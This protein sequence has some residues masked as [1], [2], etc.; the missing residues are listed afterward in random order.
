MDDTELAD[1]DADSAK[2]GRSLLVG[3]IFNR[4]QRFYTLVTLGFLVFAS[5]TVSVIAFMQG[6]FI[7]QVINTSVF[8][9]TLLCLVLL[10]RSQEP[11][12]WPTYVAVSFMHIVVT[13]GFVTNGGVMFYAVATLPVIP[14]VTALL[15]GQRAAIV[16][17][18]YALLL[19]ICSGFLFAYEMHP[20]NITKA[21]YQPVLAVMLA[22]LSVSSAFVGFY[23]L[24]SASES[25]EMEV[26]KYTIKLEAEIEGR[27]RAEEKLVE[28]TAAKTHFLSTISHE[29]RTPLNSIVGFTQLLDKIELPDRGQHC[30]DQI[31]TSSS[32]LLRK[33]DNLLELTEILFDKAELKMKPVVIEDVFSSLKSTC[34][35]IERQNGNQL[36]F[37]YESIREEIVVS[38]VDKVNCI[39]RHLIDNALKFTKE[40]KITV[41]ATIQTIDADRMLICKV[42][43]SGIGINESKIDTLFDVF[44]QSDMSISRAYEG[45]GLGLASSYK[46]TLLLGGSLSAKNNSD[47]GCTF[48]LKLP[49]NVR[50]K[51]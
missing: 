2:A 36:I 43:D 30:A 42:N 14:L 20:Q 25:S 39:M 18:G 15:L 28:A 45:I 29:L 22:A 32:E 11:M 33:V 41:S 19:I 50:D 38:D 49:V 47:K 26:K 6:V 8:M 13:S 10:Y 31:L 12:R 46:L 34:S 40:G 23:S 51:S 1:I 3:D 16:S 5:F 44:T 17:L 27:V 35:R 4:K 21:E 7:R 48:F 37:D 9:V 24:L